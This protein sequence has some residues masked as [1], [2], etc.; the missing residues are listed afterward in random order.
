MDDEW[1]RF[2][3]ETYLM[4]ALEMHYEYA[5][6]AVCEHGDTEKCAIL[7]VEW[8]R[9]NGVELVQKV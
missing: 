9:S 2:E 8:L 1:W 7:M 3:P 5:P 4:E 6:S